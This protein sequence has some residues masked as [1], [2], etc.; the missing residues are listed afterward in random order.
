LYE[1][2]GI[3]LLEAM[4]SGKPVVATICGGVP[5]VVVNGKTGLLVPPRKPKE[6]AGAC[7]K[8]LQ[9]HEMMQ[10]MGQNGLNRVLKQFSW[11]LIIKKYVNAY[12]TT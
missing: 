12:M 4:A 11:D 5:E 8:I 3:V 2:F 6:L 1:A 9:N 7:I 10:K